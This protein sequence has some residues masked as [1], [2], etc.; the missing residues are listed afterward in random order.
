MGVELNNTNQ[1][2]KL[3]FKMKSNNIE[4]NKINPGDNI[5][6]ILV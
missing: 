4:F 3:L 5:F 2:D 1:L 6:N